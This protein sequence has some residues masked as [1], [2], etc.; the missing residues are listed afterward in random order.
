VLVEYPI[1]AANEALM[2]Q[3]KNNNQMYTRYRASQTFKELQDEVDK[4]DKYKQQQEQGQQQ[5]PGK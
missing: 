4:Y 5:A 3:I 1:G 2:Q